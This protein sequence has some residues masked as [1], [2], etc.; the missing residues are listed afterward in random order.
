[1]TPPTETAFV[2][3]MSPID[4]ELGATDQIAFDARC[5]N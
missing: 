4:S 3:E 5:L 1:V 2:M